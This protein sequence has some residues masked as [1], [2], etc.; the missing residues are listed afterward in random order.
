MKYSTAKKIV[1]TITSTV[2]VFGMGISW[3]H[4]QN[5]GVHFLG[6]TTD[7][8][9]GTAGV[10]PIGNWNNIGSSFSSGSITASGGASSATLSLSGAWPG[11]GGWNSGEAGNGSDLSLLH[12]FM[13]AGNPALSVTAT[14]SGLPDGQLF[15]VYL[16]AFGDSG[17]PGGTGNNL[18]NY[19]VNGNVAYAAVLGV[20][21]S[22][23]TANDWAITTGFPGF[24]AG[25]VTNANTPCEVPVGNFGNY[26][27]VSNVVPVAGTITV[28]S[29]ADMTSFRSPMNGIEIVPASGASF[30]VHFL[31]N[32]TSDLVTGTAGVVPIGNWNNIDNG[33][34]GDGNATTLT[35]SDGT[36]TATLTLTGENINETWAS[37]LT[38]D[39]ANFSLMDGYMDGPV[40]GSSVAAISGLTGAVY[41]VYI[42]CLADSAKPGGAGNLLPNYAVNNVTNYVP[43]LGKGGSS[44]T[45][46][47]SVGGYF[48]GFVEGTTTNL[49]N[50][51]P[52][53]IADYGNYIVVTNVVPV[54]GAI[55]IVPE[56]DSASYRSPLNGIEIV[57]A[58]GAGFGI[59]FLGNSTSDL[60]TGAAGVVPIGNWNNIDNGAYV[61]GTATS[62]TGSDGTSSATLTMTGGQ[63]NNAWNSGLTGDGTNDSLMDGFMDTGTYGGTA[64]NIA[65]SGLTAS[66]YSVYLYCL[67]DSTKPSDAGQWLPNYAV[68][69]SVYYV[70]VLGHGAASQYI[71]G[72]AVG[73][74]FSGYIQAVST[75]ANS[76]APVPAEA[77]GNFI[78]FTNV[79]ATGG[80]ITVQAETDTT[81]FR[82]PLDGFELVSVAP[83]VTAQL[84]GTQIVLNWT[85]GILLQ[86]PSLSGPWTTNTVAPP[87]AVTNDLT[88]PQM[89]Y[90]VLVP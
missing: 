23:Y 4:A 58:T 9:S 51:R 6:N 2:C 64:A 56:V 39:G 38:G 20:A 16:Y 74:N 7:D 72:G 75:N 26:I 60:V 1:K 65:I 3:L 29:E 34:Y 17:K 36:T 88:A 45:T 59:H 69:G 35:G 46:I 57:P 33:G 86:A 87:Y 18:P 71:Q 53:I 31:G 11:D 83:T 68:N 28:Q 49:N 27:V 89:F 85:T 10:V 55:T 44:F 48:T 70:P 19:S 52:G 76:G 37:G 78:E 13:D 42:Y 80:Q 54:G 41:N 24:I 73:G 14:V 21:A 8:V 32:A 5:Y 40:G 25:T 12:G 90:R 50:N 77:F 79:V 15:N 81:S 67:S 43:V 30:G 62:L 84:V 22:T 66:S 82:S 63:V 61:A 47:A